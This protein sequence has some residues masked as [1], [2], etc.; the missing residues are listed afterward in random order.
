MLQLRCI[1]G[2]QKI[3]HYDDT[4]L[5]MTSLG[6]W[7]LAGLGGAKR[8]RQVMIRMTG[9]ADSTTIQ[10]CHVPHMVLSLNK[11]EATMPAGKKDM[12]Q[13]VLVQE[14]Q[15]AFS[16]AL[17]ER[18]MD[19][20]TLLEVAERAG[21]P[22]MCKHQQMAAI[23]TVSGSATM[24]FASQIACLAVCPVHGKVSRARGTHMQT[25]A[26]AAPL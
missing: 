2:Q 1:L 11:S 14:S 25:R 19:I 12:S 13:P 4:S 15:S 3:P 17:V 5:N 24:Q 10:Y 8:T 23:S 16:A 18:S 26:Q 22:P 9:T 6:F 7:P 20:F 21:G